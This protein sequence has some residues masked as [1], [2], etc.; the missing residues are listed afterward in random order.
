MIEWRR[1]LSDRKRCIAM[2]CIPLLCLALF[3]YQKCHGN[4][5][6][7]LPEAQAYRALLT[8]WEGASNQ[9][10]A[11]AYEDNWSLTPDEQRL[12][13]QAKHLSTYRDYLAQIQKQAQNQQMSSVFNRNQ[14]SFTYRNI[15]KTAADFA[16]MSADN[17]ALGNDRAVQDW[18]K[19]TLA[20]WFFLAAMVL[21]VMSFLDE[22]KKG[23][24]AIIRSCPAGRTK[25]QLSRLG[26]LLC[27]SAAMTVLLYGLPLALSFAVDGGWDALGRPVQSLAEFQKCTVNTTILGFLAGFF[28]VKVASG[29]FLGVLLWF[30]LS[31]LE[32]VQLCWLVTAA[33][34]AG[35]Y[36]LYTIIQ[37]LSILSPLRE[38]NVFS[39]VFTSELFTKYQNINFFGFPVGRQTFL[40]A[41]LAV[42]VGALSIALL[43]LL[44]RRYPF[45]NRDMLARWLRIWNRIGDAVRRPLGLL[46]FEWYKLLFLSAGGLFLL[47]GGILTRDLV[48]NSG[49]YYD[50]D[51]YLYQQYVAEVQGPVTGDTWDYLETARQRLANA[52][53]DTADFHAALDRL[54][55]TVS[56][57]PEGAWIVD[58]IP[59]LNIYGEKAWRTQRQN[60]LIAL[61]FLTTCLSPL[62]ACDQSGDLRKILRSTPRGRQTL[63]WT[64]YAVAFGVVVLVW[65]LVFFREWMTAAKTLRGLLAAPCSSIGMLRGYSMRIGT[66]LAFLYA[67]KA[68]SLMVPM[69]LCVLIGSCCSGFEKTFLISGLVLLIPAAVYA[70][71][72]DA[73]GFITV[74]PL[75]SAGFPLLGLVIW[76]VLS[77]IAVVWAGRYRT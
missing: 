19:F 62:F 46:G 51:S 44:P 22:R 27:Y 60:A 77:T 69:H 37:P 18:L 43:L 66:Y 32:H 5:S 13:E 25:L 12:F 20:D 8:T 73:M 53:V 71:G 75:L 31:F 48:Y 67:F 41:F 11:A 65:L 14:K 33:G 36:L 9:E 50:P 57:L 39:Y 34:L 52:E 28:L 23:L 38:V 17:T 29:V 3:F 4:F 15:L 70:F 6:A 61:I 21:L 68:V 55:M 10:I 49:M 45:G 72:F 56:A 2:L 42:A 26:V 47:L 30:A 16:D 58:E 74:L 76:M 40:L 1:I 64:K 24:S 35:E 59:F 63:F 7:M 54:E